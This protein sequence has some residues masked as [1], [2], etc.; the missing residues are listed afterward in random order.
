MS[1]LARVTSFFA[2]FLSLGP[3]GGGGGAGG[4]DDRELWLVAGERSPVS[5][6]LVSLEGALWKPNHAFA[7]MVGYPQAELRAMTFQQITHPDDLDADLGLFEEALRGERSSYR[8]VKRYLRSDGRVMWGDLSVALIRSEDGAP[9]HFMSLVLDVTAQRLNLDRL[10]QAVEAAESERRLSQ[11]ILDTVDVGLLLVARDGSY[12]RV[13]RRQHDILAMVYPDGKDGGVGQ[14]GHLYAADGLTQLTEEQ[15][16]AA[17]AANGEE[18]SDDRVWVGTDLTRRR[19]LSVSARTVRDTA[20][21]FVGAALAFS[22]VTDLVKALRAREVFESSVSHELRTPLTTVLGHLEM[23]LDDGDL[24]EV[25]AQQVRIVQRNATRLRHLVSDLLDPASRGQGTVALLWS[26]TDIAG[27]V[28]E[29][30]ESVLPA[31]LDGGV[32]LGAHTHGPVHAVVDGDRVR[33]VL[34]N[35]ISNAVKY[36]DAGGRV[37]VGLVVEGD[38]VAITVA[39]TGIGIAP[40]DIERLFDPF[41]RT[42][43]ARDRISPGLGLGLGIV[44]SIVVAHGGQIEIDSALGQGSSFQITL[45]LEA[46]VSDLGNTN[47]E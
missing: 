20:G 39:D 42:G 12:E 4:H 10:S 16:P 22:D 31:A 21:E 32:M 36:T 38:M 41:F 33:Q 19:A 6:C 29:A 24:S 5:M 45:P 35:L 8:L 17:R 1:L 26:S 13:N 37:D 43:R 11:A 7:E 14:I 27:L 46:P 47:A 28:E 25:A 9:L 40:E 15:M 23:L 3:A 18:F 30:V 2:D 44:Q 34:E